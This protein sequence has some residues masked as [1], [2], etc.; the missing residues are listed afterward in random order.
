MEGSD[1]TKSVDEYSDID[2]VCCS[3]DGRV[4]DT[5]SRLDQI[6]NRIGRAD[7]TYEQTGRPANNRYKVYHLEETPESLLIDV[8]F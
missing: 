3:E 4:E 2:L 6:L 5:V 7:I 8:T 1:G